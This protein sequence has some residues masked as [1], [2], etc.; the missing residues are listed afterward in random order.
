MKKL[1]NRLLMA[2]LGLMAVSLTSCDDEEIIGGMIVG[3]I[4]PERQ[5]IV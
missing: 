2:M 3:G 1:F 4:L 5:L